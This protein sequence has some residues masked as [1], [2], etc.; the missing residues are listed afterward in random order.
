MKG[1]RISYDAISD[2]LIEVIES[3]PGD[4]IRFDRLSGVL[5]RG[6]GIVKGF[7]EEYPDEKELLRGVEADLLIVLQRY[8]WFDFDIKGKRVRLRPDVDRKA[9]AR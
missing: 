5:F 8:P 9:K 6:N 3:E 2:R 7:A 4:W 1:E